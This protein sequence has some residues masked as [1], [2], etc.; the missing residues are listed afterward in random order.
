MEDVTLSTL[1][2]GDML[3]SANHETLYFLVWNH[4][5][6]WRL[7]HRDLPEHEIFQKISSDT[8]VSID[9]SD[10]NSYYIRMKVIDIDQLMVWRMSQE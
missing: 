6:Y 1:K 9:T 4:Y 10:I 3:D 2:N 7:N 8:G 5:W